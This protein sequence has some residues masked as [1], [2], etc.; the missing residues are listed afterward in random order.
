VKILLVSERDELKG[1]IRRN[2]MPRGAE[3]I[4]YYNPIK[5]MD[6]LD[7]VEPDVVLFSARDFPRHWKPFL[8]FLRDSKAREQCVFVIL[9]GD[10]FDHE[11]ADKAQALQ[12]NGIVHER[13]Q[14]REELSRLKDLVNRYRDIGDARTEKRLAP[15][16]IDRIAFVLTHPTKMEIVF[17]RVEDLSAAGVSFAPLDRQK[18]MDLQVGAQINVCSLRIGENILALPARIVRN[19]RSISLAFDR[20]S[21]AQRAMIRSYIDGHAQRELDHLAS[22]TPTAMEAV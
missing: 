3:I 8:I 6:N 22:D 10:D 1:Y 4:Q 13:L 20:L 12:V 2:F 14:N 16:Q 5:A 9:R 15:S 11:E 18:T 17:G 7:E 21:D 19:E